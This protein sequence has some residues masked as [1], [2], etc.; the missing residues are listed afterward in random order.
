MSYFYPGQD[1]TAVTTAMLQEFYAGTF[2]D[3][4]I[5]PPL[6][7]G[8]NIAGIRKVGGIVGTARQGFLFAEGAP[9]VF[10]N[11]GD[12]PDGQVLA[13]DE[14]LIQRQDVWVTATHKQRFNEKYYT[15]AGLQDTARFGRVHR[16]M[17]DGERDRRLARAICLAARAAAASSQSQYIHAGG[18]QVVNTTAQA[19]AALALAA[20]YP[21]N[22]AT[23]G[24]NA[25]DDLSNLADK[26]DRKN[27]PSGVGER[28]LWVTTDFYNAL[29]AYNDGRL[30][31]KD[32]LNTGEGGNIHRREVELVHGF[33]IM[34]KCMIDLETS[35]T[36][37]YNGGIMPATNVATGPSNLQGNFLPGASVG[38]PACFGAHSTPGGVPVV[39]YWEEGEVMNLFESDPLKKIDTWHSAVLFQCGLANPSGAYSIEVSN[40]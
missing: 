2:A 35:S 1:D 4:N 27:A 21:R 34:G 29:L 11:P 24:T 8:Q 28:P 23:G 14:Y 33:T 30:F 13:Q 26:L 17:L 5:P 31:S 40:T 36:I 37:G 22:S 15:P 12:E 6:L 10:Q 38:S 18:T 20:R 32:Y 25:Y 16:R 39:E 3:P 9:P 7:Y 19:T